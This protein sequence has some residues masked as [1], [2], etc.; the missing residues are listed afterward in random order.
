MLD[1]WL[2]QAELFNDHKNV[3]SNTQTTQISQSFHT[4]MNLWMLT[5]IV[6][7]INTIMSIFKQNAKILW[8]RLLKYDCDFPL[9]FV[10]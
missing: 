2:F 3:F 10:I 4:V 5:W 9:L 1:L 8:L 7:T 6:N